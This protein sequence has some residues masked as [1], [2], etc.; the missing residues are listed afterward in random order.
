M[1]LDSFQFND[2]TDALVGISDGNLK[3]WYSPSLAFVDKDLLP[4]SIVQVDGGEVGRNSQVV[5]YTGCRISARKV[6]GSIIF[7]STHVDIELLYEFSRSGRWDESLR[8]CRH[9]RSEPL[10]AALYGL[11]LAKK[12]LDTVE[13][14]LAELNEVPK[15]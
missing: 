8:L 7:A 4:L 14:C 11:S 13:M 9:Q 6:D 1:H 12:Q 2:E 5:S 15:V 3:V 10:W